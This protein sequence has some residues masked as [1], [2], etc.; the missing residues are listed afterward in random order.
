MEAVPQ[1]CFFD[2]GKGIPCRKRTESIANTSF[3]TVN[4]GDGQMSVGD[5]RERLNPGFSN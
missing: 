1:H 5:G 2:E 4:G 3:I